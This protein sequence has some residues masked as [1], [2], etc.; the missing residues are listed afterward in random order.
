MSRAEIYS[1]AATNSQGL[2]IRGFRMENV[3]GPHL[4]ATGLDDIHARPA[5][6]P[7]VGRCAV[8]HHRVAREEEPVLVE[9]RAGE[10][11]KRQ[12]NTWRGV[13][14]K[15]NGCSSA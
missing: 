10:Q 3:R 5:Y 14:E 6:D 11:R 12:R 4:V 13:K 1:R 9:R 7:P 15:H 2:A 8:E